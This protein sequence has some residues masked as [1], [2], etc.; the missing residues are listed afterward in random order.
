MSA[1]RMLL[2][3]SAAGHHRHGLVAAG[4]VHASAT[5]AL[6]RFFPGLL[7][8]CAQSQGRDVFPGVRAA[9]HHAG[10][11][12]QA[13]GVLLLGLL[14]NLNAM[15]VNFGWALAAAWLAK[16]VSAVQ[17]GMHWLERGA[18]LMFIGFGLK[19]ATSD[20]PAG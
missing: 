19:L 11:R 20:N 17:R 5:P 16:R 13:A 3:Q 15:W 1:L 4:E 12:Q 2:A 8:Q 6:K 10:H 18:G 7:D 9:V 14:F